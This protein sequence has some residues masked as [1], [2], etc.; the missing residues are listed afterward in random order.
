[1]RAAA[2]RGLPALPFPQ[3]SDAPRFFSFHV[4]RRHGINPFDY[5]KDLFTRLPVA[6]ITQ[7]KEFTPVARARTKANEKMPGQAA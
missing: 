4:F 7:I 1:M 6:E 3:V 5:L 2:G